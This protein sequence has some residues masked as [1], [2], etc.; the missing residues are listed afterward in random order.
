MSLLCNALKTQLEHL[1]RLYSSPCC[2]L[3]CRQLT[4]VDCGSI[5]L[6][7][8]ALAFQHQS[9]SRQ[10]CATVLSCTC[11]P[12]NHHEAIFGSFQDVILEPKGS[13]AVCCDSAPF[14]ADVGGNHFLRDP[15]K[16]MQQPVGFEAIMRVW[17]SKGERP[18]LCLCLRE[19]KKQ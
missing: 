5:L 11:L 13:S 7:P 17:T 9:S 16:D 8:L 15:R 3:L 10:H 2:F 14:Q 1:P 12:L 4:V 6:S 18:P 19:A